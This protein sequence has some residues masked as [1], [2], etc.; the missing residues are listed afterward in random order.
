[1]PSDL[2]PMQKHEFNPVLD[3]LR[4]LAVRLPLMVLLGVASA[5][6]Q[7]LSLGDSLALGFGQA[8]HL[9]TRAVVGASSCRILGMTPSGH[10]DFVLLSAGTND[11]PGRCIEAIRARLDADHVEWVLPVNGSRRHVQEVAAANG[12]SVLTYT[13][14]RGRGWPHPARYFD[15]RRVR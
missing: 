10:Y 13:P 9:P 14:G 12:D 1:M 2:K 3:V 5:H 11:V 15:V 4:A 6:G 7:D 8:S